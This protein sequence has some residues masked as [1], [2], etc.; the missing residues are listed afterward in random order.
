M[1]TNKIPLP[2]LQQAGSYLL[3]TVASSDGAVLTV[4]LG[5]RWLEGL[6]REAGETEHPR[7][8]VLQACNTLAADLGVIFS[9]EVE[10]ATFYRKQ[11]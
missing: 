11:R 10:G 2:F 8:L 3:S 7:R 9:S 5:W 6:A 4:V 1:N